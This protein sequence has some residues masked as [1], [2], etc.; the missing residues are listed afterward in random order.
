MI[1]NRKR[2]R[3]TFLVVLA[4]VTIGVAVVVWY[5]RGLYELGEV[6]SAIGS[7]RTMVDAEKTFAK[8]NPARGYTCD[9]AELSAAN[10]SRVQLA[11]QRNGYM[12]EITGCGNGAAQAPSLL[13]QITARPLH[14]NLPAFCSDQSGILRS[15]ENGSVVDCLQSGKPL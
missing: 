10:D 2:S 12:F 15:D 4:V 1:A 14:R 7:V 6:D 11:S 5:G 3:T 8:R 9:I 13:Y